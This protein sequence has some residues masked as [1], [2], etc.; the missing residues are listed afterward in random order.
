MEKLRSS[1]LKTSATKTLWRPLERASSE[2]DRSTMMLQGDIT[3]HGCIYVN[4]TN[5]V[6]EYV[7]LVH[8]LL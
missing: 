8:V 7:W 6:Q 4:N 3:K 5:N 1:S 2:T